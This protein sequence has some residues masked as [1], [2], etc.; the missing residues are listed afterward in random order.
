[1]HSNIEDLLIIKNI[2]IKQM[3]A[4]KAQP[5]SLKQFGKA[6]EAKTEYNNNTNR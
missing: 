5:L 2:G 6:N 1:M 3:K 4:K